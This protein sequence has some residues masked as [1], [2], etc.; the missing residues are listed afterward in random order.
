[1]IDFST[2]IGILQN[3]DAILKDELNET[4]SAVLVGA[5][6]N[7]KPAEKPVEQP[8]PQPK[9]ERPILSKKVV[10]DMDSDDELLWN[11]KLAKWTEKQIHAR[12]LAEGRTRYSQKTIGTR[13]C[14]MKKIMRNHVDALLQAGE[15]DWFSNDVSATVEHTS[16]YHKRLVVT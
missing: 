6:D 10:A 15:T 9:K 2:D 5:G 16:A 7:K 14:R 1:M 11:L 12:F 4:G 8:A 13:F 3:L